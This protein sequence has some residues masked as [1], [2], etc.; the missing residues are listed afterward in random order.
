MNETQR[1]RLR[2]AYAALI[3]Y[4]PF[5]DDPTISE[6]LVAETLSQYLALPEYVEGLRG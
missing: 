4:D 2:K 5:K 3:G 6:R 1:E